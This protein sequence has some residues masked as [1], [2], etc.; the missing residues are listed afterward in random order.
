MIRMAGKVR[1]RQGNATMITDTI[2]NA[3]AYFNLS[4]RIAAALRFLR[5][6]NLTALGLGKHS[7]DGENAFAI[8]QEYQTKPGAQGVWEAHRRYIDVQFVQSGVEA[9]GWAPIQQMRVKQPYDSEK[10]LE[11]FDGSGQM[12]EVPAGHFAIFL[13]H[14][15]HMPGLAV[16]APQTVRKIVV[17][18]AVE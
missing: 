1:S 18:V 9:M 17:K 11:F 3:S 14:D 16:A 2:E 6:T 12:I 8:V 15:V 10:D 5:Q 4:P 13:P 7:I